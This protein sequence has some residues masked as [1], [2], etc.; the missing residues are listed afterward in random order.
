MNWTFKVGTTLTNKLP[1]DWDQ[2]QWKMSHMIVY[3][4][5][6]YNIFTTFVVNGGQ[7]KLHLLPTTREWIWES[8]VQN[9][10][11]YWGLRTRDRWHS[12]FHHQWMDCSYPLKLSLH[13]PNIKHYHQIMKENSCA[14]STMDGIS[15]LVRIIG[16]PLRT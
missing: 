7:I 14:S 5:K 9:T 6:T 10:S 11:R 2:Q 13:V 15:L 3:L 12:L 4:V 16:Q 1:N 8:M